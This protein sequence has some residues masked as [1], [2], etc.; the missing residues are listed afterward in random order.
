MGSNVLNLWSGVKVSSSIN[1]TSVYASGSSYSNSLFYQGSR[2]LPKMTFEYYILDYPMV[3]VTEDDIDTYTASFSWEMPSSDVTGYKYQYNKVSETFDD[4][5]IEL[6]PT[7]TS[8][9]LEGLDPTTKYFFRIKACYG[10]HESAM[11]IVDFKT[12][13]PDF[14]TIPYYENFDSYVVADEWIPSRRTLPDCWDYIIVCA[15][16]STIIYHILTPSH[17]MSYYPQCR[18][19][20]DCA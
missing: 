3:E 19:L 4:V 14:A 17:N 8:V 1:Y 2:F 7:A 11:T 15:S 12:T 9:T 6:P 5:W 18:A 13:C 20:A 10:E 16:I